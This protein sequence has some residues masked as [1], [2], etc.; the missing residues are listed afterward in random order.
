MPLEEQMQ[1]CVVRE[2]PFVH[3]DWIKDVS[4]GVDQRAA[5]GRIVGLQR[6]PG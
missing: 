6:V 2:K 1:L 5:V 4:N 3:V